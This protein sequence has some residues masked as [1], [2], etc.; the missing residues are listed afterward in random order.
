MTPLKER[1]KKYTPPILPSSCPCFDR[2]QIGTG[3][4]FP[5]DAV[6]IVRSRKSRYDNVLW[7]LLRAVEHHF[8]RSKEIFY[9]SNEIS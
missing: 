2:R 5:A 6:T 3:G 8:Y 4:I 1:L 7:S 9:R